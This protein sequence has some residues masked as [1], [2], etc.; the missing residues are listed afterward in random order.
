VQQNVSGKLQG[1]AQAFLQYL[2]A[3]VDLLQHEWK[4]EQSRLLGKLARAGI[5]ALGALIT[6]QLIC[7]L[8]LIAFW[9]TPWRL[10]AAAGLV[11]LFGGITWLAWRGM[12][13]DDDRDS[14]AF[15][16]TLAE[17]DK[18]RE[19]FE[20]LAELREPPAKPRNI[21]GAAAARPVQPARPQADSGPSPK[22]PPPGRPPGVA[23]T[24][25]PRP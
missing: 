2:R 25:Q 20:R 5:F 7:A 17:F 23:Q 10:H 18:D 21:E 15:S 9:D 24:A 8:V 3:R 1:L 22:M 19:I 11:L 12:Q 4:Q 13:T 6:L 16:S 14:S